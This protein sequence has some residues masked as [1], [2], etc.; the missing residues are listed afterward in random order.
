MSTDEIRNTGQLSFEFQDDG[1]VTI[2][3]N[4]LGYDASELVEA[5]APLWIWHDSVLFNDEVK[6]VFLELPQGERPQFIIDVLD[7]FYE[8][9]PEY[10]NF[11]RVEVYNDPMLLL[12]FFKS[13]TKE[14]FEEC[15]IKSSEMRFSQ[16]QKL[17]EVAELSIVRTPIDPEKASTSW[18][19]FQIRDLLTESEMAALY[20]L[21]NP[22]VSSRELARQMGAI[23]KVGGRQ[24]IISNT[25]YRGYLDTKPNKY[26]Y[27][28]YVGRDYW[29]QIET[30][31]AGNLYE[32]EEAQIIR[33]AR[34]QSKPGRRPKTRPEQD[35]EKIPEG[36]DKNL[37]GAL[38]AAMLKTSVRNGNEFTIY[39]PDFAREM[40][41][42][43]KIDV[44]EYDETGKPNSKYDK[45]RE[46][47]LHN[48]NQAKTERSAGKKKYVN[49]RPSI[50]QDLRSL[51]DWVGIFHGEEVRK[52]LN[53]VGLNIKANTITVTTPYFNLLEP[54][55]EEDQRRRVVEEKQLRAN[56]NWNR[57]IHTSM[58]KERNQEAVAVVVRITNGMLSRGKTPASKFKNADEDAAE[59]SQQKPHYS[60]S[61]RTLIKEVPELQRRYD[62]TKATADKNKLLSRTFK[63]VYELLRTKTDAYKYFVDLD[64]TEIIPTTTTLDTKLEINFTGTNPEVNKN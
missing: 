64:L 48:E 23:G 43:Y 51:N 5:D 38:F 50:M 26:A 63:K 19:I 11:S 29:D 46:E 47:E 25:R 35:P 13:I 33:K 52:I 9:N 37:A 15:S 56:P 53:I 4:I 60:I 7:K 20:Y 21:K 40:N 57:L 54:A 39:L 58:S 34:E 45:A 14:D 12:N 27:I 6:S 2:S 59:R 24:A 49:R 44:D 1:T 30:D 18:A 36:I 31:E 17:I 8:K 16:L 3:E 61:F 28:S 42:H 22:R 10:S 41:E 62:N 32:R 55:V